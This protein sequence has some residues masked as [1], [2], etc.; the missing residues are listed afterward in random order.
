VPN[1]N[2]VWSSSDNTIAT[3]SNG[4][5]TAIASGNCTISCNI[6][7]VQADLSLTVIANTSTNP[8]VSYGYNFSQ[9]TTIKEFVT[10]ILT[11]TKTI[12][13][14]SNPL[15][16]SFNFDS[17]GQSL[18]SSGKVTVTTKSSSSIAIKNVSVSTNT[19]IH[20]TVTDSSD[21]TVI[22][23]NVAITLTGM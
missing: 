16:I 21:S 5:V 17:V 2:I 9:T 23:D 3:V 18:I 13:A 6:G 22:L 8:V 15:S 1:P 19:V 20:L 14:V 12:D 10:S 4:L 7:S 11:C